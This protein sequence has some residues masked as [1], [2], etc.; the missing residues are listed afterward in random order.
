MRNRG[1][2]VSPAATNQ[3]LRSTDIENVDLS[4]ALDGLSFSTLVTVTVTGDVTLRC[5]ATDEDQASGSATYYVRELLANLLAVTDGASE[6][7]SV[8][9]WTL[10]W[11]GGGAASIS[12]DVSDAAPTTW[13]IGQSTLGRYGGLP[14]H[15][16]MA[17]PVADWSIT[18]QSTA[19]AFDIYAA[20][21]GNTARW[22]TWK[23][24]SYGGAKTIGTPS[25]GVGAYTVTI[26]NS[27]TLE[28]VTVAFTVNANEWNAAPN[29]LNDA[30]TLNQMVITHRQTSLSIG[31]VVIL[32]DGAHNP[33]GLSSTANV[34]LANRST[35]VGGPSE[36]TTPYGNTLAGV[37]PEGW[38]PDGFSFN[39]GWITT[40]PRRPYAASVGLL[41]INCAFLKQQFLRFSQIDGL[42]LSVTKHEGADDGFEWIM[43]DR[44][45]MAASLQFSAG[46]DYSRNL[47][48]LTNHFD[49]AFSSNL[50]ARDS[51]F[52]GNHLK[53]LPGNNDYFKVAIWNTTTGQRKGKVAFN[54]FK[55]A[56]Y[57]GPGPHPDFCQTQEDA[58]EYMAT[59]PAATVFE[60]HDHY[61]NVFV[62]GVGEE[63][64][65][66]NMYPDAQGCIIFAHDVQTAMRY[67]RRVVGNVGCGNFP[68]ACL[69]E[70][71]A[72]GSI[73]RNNTIVYPEIPAVGGLGIGAGCVVI[74]DSGFS[75]PIKNNAI[76]GII[77]DGAGSGAYTAT[78]NLLNIYEGGTVDP[79]DCY[80]T[81]DA[82]W[83]VTSLRDV[84][85][86]YVPLAEGPLTVAG[87]ASVTIGAL[88]TSLINQRAWTYDTAIFSA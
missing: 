31:D 81:P 47:F 60:S 63:D 35:R 41:T 62:R 3:T 74:E 43:V 26:T 53:N 12:F 82:G 66:G 64:G 39:D 25:T 78:N 15:V 51:Q 24:A 88:G 52:V 19:N 59:F 57:P 68:N 27:T 1:G 11:A 20:D 87:G 79:T 33:T 84:T 70:Y 23:S 61:G 55:N 32:E 48:I 16:Y 8:G 71:Y 77:S 73:I 72:N 45:V 17:G 30:A 69:I 9:T 36:P 29:A 56:Q 4:D 14:L 75:V 65:S 2:G 7:S 58:A 85:D 28:E 18:S 6:G 50:Y 67:I 44:C 83:G 34:N 49:D 86:G 80:V 46:S 40:R 10:T 37:G 42:A 21:G 22:L 76:A 54:F 13:T 38:E 5:W